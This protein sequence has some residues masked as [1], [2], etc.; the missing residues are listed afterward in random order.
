MNRIKTSAPGSTMLLGEYAVLHDGWALVCAVDQRVYVTLTPRAD[1]KIEIL[2]S[3]GAHTATLTQLEV[4]PP[5][6][7]VLAVLKK[8]QDQL[9]TGCTL[10]IESDFSEKIGLASSAAVTV[11]TLVAIVQWLDI[12]YS[13]I[14]L[15][16][17]ARLIVQT[18]QGM[19]SG[20]DV[21]ACVLGGIIAYH[22]EPLEVEK[23]HASCPLHLIYSGSKTPTAVVVNQVETRFSNKPELYQK[24]L[25]DIDACTQKAISALKNKNDKELGEAMTRQ[26]NLMQALGVNTP[27]LQSIV[28]ELLSEPTIL[29]AK[30]SGSGL[31]DSVIAL[32]EL[33]KD[34]ISRFKD[35]GVKR[36]PMSIATEGV[37]CEKG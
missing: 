31:G 21:A 5:F 32:G 13:S 8:H 18:V 4:I 14:E 23:I 2:S 35:Q 28:D 37:R 3:L 10:I 25:Q 7:F 27:L 36:I 6:Q 16:Q 19:G 29:G 26:Q 17:H 20:A 22:R 30:I 33:K 15:I 1:D 12:N 24:I 11:A 34:Y 9:K